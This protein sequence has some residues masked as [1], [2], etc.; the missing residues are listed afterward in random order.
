MRNKSPLSVFCFVAQSELQNPEE[1]D[2]ESEDFKS[3]PPEIQ[4]EILT[5]MR[6]TRKEN[7]WARLEEMPEVDMADVFCLCIGYVHT[8]NLLCESCRVMAC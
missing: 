1:V 4:H 6:E 5:N 7:Y 8:K 3:F 2:I